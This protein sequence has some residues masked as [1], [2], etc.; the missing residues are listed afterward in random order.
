MKL[1]VAC[2]IIGGISVAPGMIK[3][4]K[5]VEPNLD[6][7]TVGT[8]EKLK[9]L[10]KKADDSRGYY[11]NNYLFDDMITFNTA[12]TADLAMPES[13]VS[14]SVSDSDYST[15]NVQVEGVDE[16]DIIKNDGKYLYHLLNNELIVSEIN[17]ASTMK[18]VSRISYD[19]DF[20]LNE[21]Y[22]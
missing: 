15:T 8:V 21:L 20:S 5:V 4:E 1:F 17:P 19:K 13:T 14:D 9:E 16:A 6:L 10:V 22:W 2:G 18:V 11:R 7:P 12:K 3:T